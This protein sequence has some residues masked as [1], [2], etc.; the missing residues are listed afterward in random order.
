MATMPI[1]HYL[2]ATGRDPYQ[3]WLDGL[4]DLTARVAIQRRIDRVATGNLGEHNF[5]QDGVWELK[6]DIGPGY[7][8]YYALGRGTLM[9]LLCG[10]S[11]R[12]QRADIK[13]AVKFWQEYQQ[14]RKL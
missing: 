3:E 14:R 12:T 4:R 7:R 8:V 5:L 13:T 9:L 2:T 11:K 10:E 6:I 1:R